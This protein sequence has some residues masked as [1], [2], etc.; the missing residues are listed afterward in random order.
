VLESL[1]GTEMMALSCVLITVLWQL[2]LS[3]FVFSFR[4]VLREHD[5]LKKSHVEFQLVVV[6]DYATKHELNDS[7]VRIEHKLDQLFND[8]HRGH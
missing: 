7:V 6:R 4:R 3:M 2:F 1:N 8:V 5:E